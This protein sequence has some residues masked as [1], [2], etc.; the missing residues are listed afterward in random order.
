MTGQG[1]CA[2]S[3]AAGIEVPSLAALAVMLVLL[4]GPIGA[5]A[6]AAAPIEPPLAAR[7][8]GTLGSV[9]GRVYAEYRRAGA[10]SRPYASVSALLLPRSADFEAEIAAIKAH[11]HD[12]PDAYIEAEPTVSAAGLTFQQAPCGERG[13]ALQDAPPGLR[14]NDGEPLVDASY[15][16]AGEEVTVRLHDR[17]EW[18][19]GVRDDRRVPDADLPASPRTQQGAGPR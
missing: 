4:R 18:L 16:E 15:R 10:E 6:E 2:R 19:A 8:R 7:E 17:N 14:P 11:S 3:A 9:G 5:A 12:S 1:S 13:A